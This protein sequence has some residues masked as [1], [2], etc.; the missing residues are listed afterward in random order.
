VT[1]KYPADTS[2]VIR[3]LFDAGVAGVRGHSG[4][5]AQSRV[6]SPDVTITAVASYSV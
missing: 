4:T 1:R 2:K 6:P 5:L 3:I